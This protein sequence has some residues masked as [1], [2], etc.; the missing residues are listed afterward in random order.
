MW[1]NLWLY[2]NLDILSFS[3]T[4]FTEN[5]LPA[6]LNSVIPHDF[7]FLHTPRPQKSGGGVAVIYCSQLKAIISNNN[8]Y[9]FFKVIGIKF[10]IH[11]SNFIIYT[12]YPLLSTFNAHFFYRIFS[13]TWR[14]HISSFCNH[15]FGNFNINIDTVTLPDCVHIPIN[16]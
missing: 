7:S 5:T 4:C 3:E 1:T 14:S 16:S 15:F 6:V 8:S 13:F 10:S 12:K 2:C 11:N 9:N